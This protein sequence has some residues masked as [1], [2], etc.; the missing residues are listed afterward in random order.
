MD[1]NVSDTDIEGRIR[2]TKEEGV[3]CIPVPYEPGW[4]AYVD[5]IPTEIIR[6]TDGIMGVRVSDSSSQVRFSFMPVGLKTGVFVTFI[7]LILAISE[8]LFCRKRDRKSY[9]QSDAP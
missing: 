1:V 3:V 9:G 7:S 6:L 5:N 2:A 8:V 4:K